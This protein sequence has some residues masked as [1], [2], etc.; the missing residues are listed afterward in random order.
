MNSLPEVE[1]A[2]AL[3]EVAAAGL[4]WSRALATG[5]GSLPGTDAVE[6]VRFVLGELPEFA[7]L[8]ELPARG[9]HA[10][11][12]G[13]SAALLTDLWV[14]LQPSGWR[15]TPRSSRDGIRARDEL[16]RDLDALEEAA[17]ESPPA[18]LKVQV[19][20]PWTLVSLLELNRGERAL[21]DHGAVRDLADSLAEGLRLHLADVQRRVPTAVVVLQLDE[22]SLPA[23]LGAR[24]R[25]SSGVATLRAPQPQRAREV[26]A[27]VLEA[28]RHTIVHCC[29][30]SPPITL[31]R[32]AGAEALAL[33]ATLLRQSDDD[34]LG[35]AVEAG[36]GL[37]LGCVAGT[38]AP[39][40][41]VA[42][43]LAPVR[44][45]WR[46]LGLDPARLPEVV[47]VTPTCGL[48]GSTPAYAR[49]ALRHCVEAAAALGEE[50][51]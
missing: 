27:T 13:R 41:A 44:R 21:A 23:V 11:L 12:A 19:A 45:L 30:P 34:A 32:E 49:Q 51:E 17:V 7:F 22:P 50:P 18:L 46:R 38:D 3:E 8:P 35:E 28:G 31:M 39:L 47:V 26:L 33:D 29:A 4:P 40:P 16:T 5:I 48:A 14:D 37:L 1:P 24:I 9:P 42:D 2:S 36:L 10:D 6:A 15:L 25:T 43:S 20:G